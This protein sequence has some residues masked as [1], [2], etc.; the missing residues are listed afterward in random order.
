[1]QKHWGMAVI[2]ILAFVALGFT[3][4]CAVKPQAGAK[5]VEC[6]VAPET[7]EPVRMTGT[8]QPT[9]EAISEQEL[10]AQALLARQQQFRM[11]QELFETEMIHFEFDRSVIIP[12]AAQI[13][14][15]KAAFLKKYP[16]V[17]ILVEG[18][19]DERGTLEYNLALGER[20]AQ[21]AKS[22][23]VDRGIDPKRIQTVSYGEERPMRPESTE[24]AWALNRRC[25]FRVQ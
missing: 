18:H 16:D 21:A 25:E 20:R 11:D 4:S 17:R 23:L 13:L 22:Y 24:E 14:N 7:D 19:C 8:A 9:A 1:M 3:T 2:L 12:A 15:R 5:A 10:R 6:G